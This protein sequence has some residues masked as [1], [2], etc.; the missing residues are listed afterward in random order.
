MKK[1]KVTKKQR[2]AKVFA[3]MNRNV[4][5]E[6]G[7]AYSKSHVKMNGQWVVLEATFDSQGQVVSS[8]KAFQDIMKRRVKPQKPP[9]PQKNFIT[10]AV[11]QMK[12][13]K[14]K[15]D[16]NKEDNS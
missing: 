9:V 13:L 3:K 2:T 16:D 4:V 1:H 14:N 12:E 10:Q 6:D 15:K 7:S 11:E 8:N 5:L